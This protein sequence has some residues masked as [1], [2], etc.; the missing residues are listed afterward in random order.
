[1][2]PWLAMWAGNIIFAL[3][4][5]ILVRY[6]IREHLTIRFPKWFGKI[7]QKFKKK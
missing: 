5:M 4:G 2:A 1:M 6:A 7:I 3:I